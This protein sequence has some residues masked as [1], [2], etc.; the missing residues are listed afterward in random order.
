[1]LLLAR[2]CLVGLLSSQIALLKKTS[3]LFFFFKILF[4]LVGVVLVSHCC[5][6]KR[7]W[8]F[9]FLERYTEAPSALWIGICQSKDQL[10]P[11]HLIN[12]LINLLG[13]LG[14]GDTDSHIIEKPL[15][16]GDDSRKLDHSMPA[17]SF[18]GII[19]FSMCAFQVGR[20]VMSFYKC[21]RGSSGMSAQHESFATLLY[22]PMGH[23]STHPPTEY[24]DPQ[25]KDSHTLGYFLINMLSSSMAEHF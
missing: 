18:S 10:H 3:Q 4:C 1:M 19:V 24:L 17:V 2:M 14:T 16:R 22:V 13:L 11:L 15:L 25:I 5:Y 8:L 21:I 20:G 7:H 9:Y 12:A 23:T 6:N